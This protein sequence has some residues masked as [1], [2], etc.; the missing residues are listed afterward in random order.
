[1]EIVP[2]LSV[3]SIRYRNSYNTLPNNDRDVEFGESLAN[4]SKLG[5]VTNVDNEI[6]FA[7]IPR[8]G[9]GWRTSCGSIHPFLRCFIEVIQ[10]QRLLDKADNTGVSVVNPHRYRLI[11][12]KVVEQAAVYICV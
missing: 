6:I 7:Q 5:Q 1:M 11:K 8:V 12:G 10:Q 9:G 4:S 3:I 2:C